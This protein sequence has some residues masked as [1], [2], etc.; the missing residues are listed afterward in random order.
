M[1]KPDQ[2]SSIKDADA[3]ATPYEVTMRA[4][5]SLVA[6]ANNARSHTQ[7]QVEQLA[8]SIREFGWTNPLIIHGDTVVAGHARLAAAAFLGLKEVPVID[9][10]DMTEERWK[11]YVIADNQLASISGWDDD[12]LR[13]ELVGLNDADFNMVTLGFGSAIDGLLGLIT[14]ATDEWEG[15]PEYESEDVTSDSKVIVHFRSGSDRDAFAT[16]VGQVLTGKTKYIWHPEAE[17]RS[18]IDKQYTAETNDGEASPS[19]YDAVAGDDHSGTVRKE[20]EVKGIRAMVRA[21]TSDEFVV[22][23]VIGSN[24]YKRLG[25]QPG[26]VVLDIGF[27]IGM[28]S[29]WAARRGASVIHA[30][31]P[32]PDNFAVAT[33]NVALNGH[34]DVVRAVMVAVIGNDDATRDFS[35]NVK[36]N[37]GAHSLIKK[38][39]RDTIVVD[40]VNINAEIS[41]H[42]PTVL[43]MDTEGG[44]YEIVTSI[45][46]WSGI[47]EVIMEFHHA[48]LNDIDT[49]EKYHEVVAIIEREFPNV[50]ARPSDE[51]G[52]AWTSIIHGS[53]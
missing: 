28:F 45:T 50:Y 38:R 41:A 9:R 18:E 40:C 35:I 3:A 13:M 39:G 52:G 23:E 42:Q 19:E 6:Y 43:K 12:L 2:R 34:A 25:I 29:V 53:K 7:E 37:K 8:A 46:D 21:N 10:S 30:Y 5:K 16:L 24:E 22:R 15:M 27:N 44:E 4:T 11:A 17:V 1:A 47:R 20:I 14:D 32:E 49:R 51:L 36:K 26:D 31:E 48:H 33:N